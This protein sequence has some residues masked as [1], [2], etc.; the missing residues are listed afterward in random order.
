V[1]TRRII[2]KEDDLDGTRAEET[3]AFSLDG[4]SYE[5]DLNTSNAA[6][7]REITRKYIAA[8]RRT[9]AKRHNGRTTRNSTAA[10]SAAEIRAWART[11]GLPIGDYGIIPDDIRRTYEQQH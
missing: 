4:T 5:I 10:G 7:L 8:A 1:A 11:H 6:E 9:S 3:V 2:I